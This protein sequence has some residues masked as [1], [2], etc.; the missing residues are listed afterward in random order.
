[1]TYFTS[2]HSLE[3]LRKEYKRLVKANHPDN[4]GSVEEIKI[5]NVEYEICFRILE[6]NDSVSSNKYD[7]AED[8]MIRE[9]I[10]TIINLNVDIEICGSWVWVS[11]NT[12]GCKDD[13]KANGFHWAS[14]K[15]L[16][17]W[18]NPEEQ[19]RSNGKTSMDDIRVKYGSQV[20]KSAADGIYISA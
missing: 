11:G 9:I 4:G 12:Y 15:K 3:E 1:M 8:A 13:L 6:K 14:K 18:H 10:N 16:W 7:M 20:V 17:Y 19:T 5:I 2:I